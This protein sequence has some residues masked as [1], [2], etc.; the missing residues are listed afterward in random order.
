[1]PRRRKVWKKIKQRRFGKQKRAA[2][3]N[4]D[5]PG[6]AKHKDV[7]IPQVPSH[8]VRKLRRIAGISKPL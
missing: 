7:R 4:K 3:A 6:V 2:R 5:L 8:R 1:M